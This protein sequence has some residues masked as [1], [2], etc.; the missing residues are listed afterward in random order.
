MASKVNYIYLQLLNIS[1]ETDISKEVGGVYFIAKE[2][3]LFIVLCIKL[4][5][6]EMVQVVAVET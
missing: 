2:S 4:R 6:K 5:K 3:F 1:A